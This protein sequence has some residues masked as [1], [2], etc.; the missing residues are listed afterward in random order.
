MR[1]QIILA[2]LFA[3]LPV[4]QGCTTSSATALAY[5]PMLSVNAPGGTVGC[6]APNIVTL[7]GKCE[8]PKQLSWK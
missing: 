7:D 8:Q 1:Y 4:L 2:A 3:A 6:M 5:D